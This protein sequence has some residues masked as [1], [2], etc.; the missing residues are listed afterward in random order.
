MLGLHW[1]L[2]VIGGCRCP[3]SVPSGLSQICCADFVYPGVFC[4]SAIKAAE[5]DTE[6]LVQ[7]TVQMRKELRDHVVSLF[8]SIDERGLG[9]VTITDFEKAFD[10]EAMQARSEFSRVHSASVLCVDADVMWWKGSILEVV[11]GSACSVST[12]FSAESPLASEPTLIDVK[13]CVGGFHPRSA[14]GSSGC[15]DILHH[16]GQGW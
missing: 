8:H 7:S 9:R 3:S 6:L 10:T 4:N 16:G 2:A 1:P 5:N 13:P 11:T 14:A 15:L 12:S